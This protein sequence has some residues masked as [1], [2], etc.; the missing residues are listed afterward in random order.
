MLLVDCYVNISEGGS[1]GLLKA[2]K[3]KRCNH[4]LEDVRLRRMR[5]T[6]QEG[7]V[8]SKRDARIIISYPASVTHSASS[9]FHA[10]TN[11]GKEY[12]PNK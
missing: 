6:K 10:S 12:S 2:V 9:T 5:A 7:Y 4:W 3:R 8:G 1:E 11:A